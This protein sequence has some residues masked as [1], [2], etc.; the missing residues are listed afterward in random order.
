MTDMFFTEKLQIKTS[1]INKVSTLD[2][3]FCSISKRV[4]PVR[5]IINDRHVFVDDEALIA[6]KALKVCEFY[7]KDQFDIVYNNVKSLLNQQTM[8]FGGGVD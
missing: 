5:L 8:V 4:I 7:N 3:H 2:T 1:Q 6:I